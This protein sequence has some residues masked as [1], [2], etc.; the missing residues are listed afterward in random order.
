MASKHLHENSS[1]CSVKHYS[2]LIVEHKQHRRPHPPDHVR[3]QASIEAPVSL[4]RQHRPET[5][6]AAHVHPLRPPRL[7]HHA[8]PNGVDRV[9]HPVTCGGAPG[10]KQNR[11]TFTVLFVT[12][13]GRMGS[14]RIK[15]RNERRC[16]SSKCSMSVTRAVATVPCLELLCLNFAKRTAM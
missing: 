14:V 15:S 12:S 4:R 11:K 16:C 9:H 1:S 13:I 3:R 8:S 2:Y 5:V 6:K 7:H 10:E